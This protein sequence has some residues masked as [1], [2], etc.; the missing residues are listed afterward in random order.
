MNL[1]S[2]LLDKL[3]GVIDILKLLKLRSEDASA[4]PWTNTSGRQIFEDFFFLFTGSVL[5][6]TY[7]LCTS[8]ETSSF[9]LVHAMICFPGICWS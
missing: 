8:Y 4:V 1:A 6:S 5:K 9:S 7:N 2:T 3:V